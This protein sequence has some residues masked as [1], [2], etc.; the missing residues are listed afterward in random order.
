MS[1]SPKCKSQ[2]KKNR[3]NK[4]SKKKNRPAQIFIKEKLSNFV[5]SETFLGAP[6]VFFSL[7]RGFKK[8]FLQAQEKE[9]FLPSGDYAPLK[10]IWDQN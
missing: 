4:I 1:L 5:N 10:R 9:D 7:I 8:T 3:K 6:R 2:K